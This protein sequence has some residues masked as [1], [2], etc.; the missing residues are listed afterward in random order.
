VIQF[1]GAGPSIW[2]FN[3]DAQTDPGDIEIVRDNLGTDCIGLCQRAD[4]NR[5]GEVDEKDLAI[6][7]SHFGPCELCGSDLNG[8][9]VVNELD[10]RL[11]KRAIKTCRETKEKAEAHGAK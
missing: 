4:L 3:G 7:K 5:D 9:G 10:V 2:D 8:D 1:Q 6:L 11:M